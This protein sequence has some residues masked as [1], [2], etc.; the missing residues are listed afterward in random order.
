MSKFI[1]IQENLAPA[2]APAPAPAP[3]SCNTLTKDSTLKCL[4]SPDMS[5]DLAKLVKNNTAIELPSLPNLTCTS[6]ISSPNGSNF[7]FTQTCSN[8]DNTKISEYKR[9]K[10]NVKPGNQDRGTLNSDCSYKVNIKDTQL[11]LKA[12]N[13]PLTT[14]QKYAKNEVTF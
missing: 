9:G 2:A 7:D 6:V 14:V 8:K 4:T 3:A 10:I 5:K 12:S 11:I 13:C 1:R